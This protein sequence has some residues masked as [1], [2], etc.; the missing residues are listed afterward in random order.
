MAFTP[1]PLYRVDSPFEHGSTAD[2]TSVSSSNSSPLK[3]LKRT[4]K[5]H[6]K[7]IRTLSMST[8]DI[9]RVRDSET[10]HP[11]SQSKFYS[12]FKTIDKHEL[13]I[14][15]Y[16]CAF[17]GDILL[18]GR[19]YITANHFAFYSKLFGH[20]T[21]ILMPC[22]SVVEVTKEK[23]A[24][25]IPNAVAVVL[26][27]GER[28]VFG[29]LLS[30]DATY[31]TMLCVW[32]AHSN[33]I[34]C[35]TP[36]NVV[37]EAVGEP[38][39]FVGTPPDQT[40]SFSTHDQFVY[41]SLSESSDDADA[42]SNN[43]GSASASSTPSPC[44]ENISQLP[45]FACCQVGG[46]LSSVLPVVSVLLNYLM[47]STCHLL[48]LVTHLRTP[49]H[50]LFLLTCNFILLLLFATSF[51]SLSRIDTIDRQLTAIQQ[52]QRLDMSAFTSTPSD[53]HQS[54]CLH[55]S[56]SYDASKGSEQLISQQLR[57]LQLVRRT[58]ET[59]TM[60]SEPIRGSSANN[61]TP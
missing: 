50:T 38:V 21:R 23:T 36:D 44:H 35:L 37:S 6:R 53:Y 17:V 26:A 34:A 29:S 4:T 9:N 24:K 16:S 18:Q 45:G 2:S 46:T 51:I 10:T 49:R 27:T 12:R 32:R 25:I 7:A 52:R 57:Q 41:N 33:P 58:L 30:R 20:V 31:E 48:T 1:A 22:A 42:S 43:S 14:K 40:E 8:P 54:E 55:A 5:K 47:T 60:S 15:S 13:I 59:L 19:L 28:R 56:H 3:L 11:R 39:V 61:I